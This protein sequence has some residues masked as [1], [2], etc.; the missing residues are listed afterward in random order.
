MFLINKFINK[1]QLRSASA[2]HENNRKKIMW[3][4][5]QLL[6]TACK[7]FLPNCFKGETKYILNGRKDYFLVGLVTWKGDYHMNN[8]FGGHK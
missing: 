7:P 3:L 8:K 1:K 2:K 4:L 5:I 6:L